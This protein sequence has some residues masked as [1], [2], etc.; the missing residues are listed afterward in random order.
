M[1]RRTLS[2]TRVGTLYTKSPRV[3]RGVSLSMS[4]TEL[5]MLGTSRRDRR[6]QLRSGLVGC[7][8]TR[9]RGARKFVGNFRSSVQAITTRPLPRRKFYNV[10]IGNARFARG[11]RTN[12]TV[13][14]I[15][16][17]GR[18]L[19]PM[20]LNDCQ[21]FGVRLTFSDFRG[22]CRMLLGNRVA[23]QIP[24]NAD[25][26]NGVRHLSGTLTKVPTELRGTRRRLSGLEDRRRTTRTRLKGPFP[27]RTRLTRGDTELTRLST[28]LGVSSH[29]GSS[30]SHRGAARGPS[31]LTR[32]HSHTK[33]VPPVARQ[34]SRRITL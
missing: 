31:I 9:V 23:R 14:T 5:G 1:S 24:V 20:P 4:I 22:R 28:L 12:R 25:T 27:R 7:F 2:C 17:T 13:L 8:P 10:R 26:T 32:L 18:D 34:S 16:G 6:C 11:T 21:N 30:P 33:H 15:Y 29:K 19:R 3:G